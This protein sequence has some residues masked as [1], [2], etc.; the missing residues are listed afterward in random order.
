[1]RPLDNSVVKSR[2]KHASFF[3]IGQRTYIGSESHMNVFFMPLCSVL[4]LYPLNY[5]EVVLVSFP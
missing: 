4:V 3:H 5:E 1:M 2:L